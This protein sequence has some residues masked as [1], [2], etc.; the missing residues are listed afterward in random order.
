MKR[1]FLFAVAG[2]MAFGAYSQDIYE[3]A[4]LSATDLNGSARYVGMGGAMSALG[5]DM[6]TMASNPASIGLF[7]H[8]DVS[9]TGSLVMRPGKEKF[10]GKHPTFASFDQIGLVYTI[11][12]GGKSL[13][14]LNLGF[15]Y[16]KNHDFNQLLSASNSNLAGHN[17]ASQTWEMADLTNYWGGIDRSTPLAIGGYQTYLIGADDNGS[18]QAYNANANQYNRASWGSNQ[19]FDFN[20]SANFSD[21]FYGGITVSAYNV[22]HKSYSEYFEDLRTADGVSDGGYGLSNDRH[23]DGTGFD[24]KFGFIMRPIHTSNFKVG[25]AITTPTY[26]DLRYRNDFYIRS[27]TES[28]DPYYY[29]IPY[30]YDFNVRTPWK[31]NLS[32][33]N[34]FF[35][36]LAVG[37]EYEFADYSACSVSYDDDDW[38]DWDWSWGEKDRALNR[39]IDK[40]LKSTHTLKVG[41]ELMIIPQLFVRAGYNYVSPSIDG[42]AFLN[43]YINSASVDAATSTDYLNLKAINRF[44]VGVGVKLG[45][46]YADM[47]W[48]YQHQN[49]DFYSFFAAED[50]NY[51]STVGE[52]HMSGKMNIAP[53]NKVSLNR[54][55]LM[56]TLGYKF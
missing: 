50:G 52:Q 24:V 51:A 44:A 31:L 11:P 2:L 32:V 18:F 42:D 23:V 15:N 9:L 35:N 38:D 29:A 46:F 13:R 37:A 26:Y 8:S 22:D 5:G 30:D 7:R 19:A 49:G 43:Q 33:G 28:Y 16:H 34:T 4:E 17:Y 3:V 10:D 27:N 48:T 6:S 55:Q 45:S 40:F 1:I 14:F 36:R 41:A 56:L 12:M 47:A 53:K 21:Q 39:Q 54:S 25:L 20:I